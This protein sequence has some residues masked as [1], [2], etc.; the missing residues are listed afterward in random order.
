MLE[1]LR[2]IG[3][4]ENEAKVY[5]ALLE[6]GSGTAQE[7]SKKS[8]VNRPTTYVQLENLMKMGLAST[9]EKESTRKGGATKT[10]FRAESPEYLHHV[11]SREK[12]VLSEKENILQN[13]APHL[14]GIFA[15]AKEHPKVR[16]F[17]GKEGLK[18]MREEYLRTVRESAIKEI[19]S[20]TSLDP[21][22]KIFPAHSEEY[23]L[24]RAKNNIRGRVIYTSKKGESLKKTDKEML[25]ESRFLPSDEFPFSHDI[26][27]YGNQVA[28]SVLNNALMGVIIENK[29]IAGSM[30]VLFDLAWKSA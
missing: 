14:A 25:R 27:I 19:V 7:I 28:F 9:Y 20:V 13:I 6:L 2:K 22:L 4:S 10:M 29:E 8:G 30:R 17:E 18:T 15:N 26:T 5:F 23:S 3:L 11:I 12:D 16:F 1:D 21:V 24:E